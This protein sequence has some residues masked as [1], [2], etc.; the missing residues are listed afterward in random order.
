MQ[1]AAGNTRNQPLQS[2]DPQ[3]DWVLENYDSQT[4][5]R[6]NI[7]TEIRRLQALKSFHMLDQ[8]VEDCYQRFA[9]LAARMFRTPMAAICLVDLGRTWFVASTGFSPLVTSREMPRKSSACAHAIL[10][11][12]P[13][14][15]VPDLS[16]D[17]RFRHTPL[18]QQENLRFYAGAPLVTP[19]GYRLGCLSILD[20]KPR[21]QGL[22]EEDQQ[23][24]QDLAAAVMDF[25]LEKR[26]AASQAPLVFGYDIQ[27]AAV[28]L[29]ESLYSLREDSDFCTI[30][31]DTHRSLLQSACTTSDHLLSSVVS[32][33]KS[34]K[35]PLLATTAS[36][37][38]GTEMASA[39]TDG[40][41]HA[42]TGTAFAPP[43]K[44]TSTS[45]AMDQSSS[46]NTNSDKQ[47]MPPPSDKIGENAATIVVKQ[48]VQNL[49]AAME[50]FPKKVHLVFRVDPAVPP[51]IVCNDLKLF[52]SAIALLTSACER[53]E[54][55]FVRLNVY[56]KQGETAP[57]Q[58]T[59]VFECEDTGR[60][61]ALEQYHDLFQT[62]KEIDMQEDE[63]LTV[64]PSTGTILTKAVCTPDIIREAPISGGF[65]VYPVAKYVES[66]GGEYGYLPRMIRSS[67]GS[68]QAVPDTGS[69]FWF[70]IP[71]RLAISSLDA[72][73]GTALGFDCPSSDERAVVG[74]DSTDLR[75]STQRRNI[76]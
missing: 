23:A 54:Q 24:L 34:A 75:L 45:T 13:V 25:V 38:K 41:T 55:G 3:P 68:G 37:C 10:C 27:R 30:A 47:Q 53:T 63:C 19:E 18:V 9:S 76:F 69:L 73:I 26:A 29:R 11:L 60:D 48:L 33:R 44:A 35:A 67:S 22:L 50:V 49:V 58:T 6:P 8:P 51:E 40:T 4:T 70:S 17:E 74:T 20:H 52:R 32:T 21:P 31:S 12:R 43:A 64:D 65:A 14:M 46:N 7:E 66:M 59:L 36:T 42:A 56:T 2:A 16:L 72:A 39:A 57:D 62:P 71:L 61:V 15:V 1:G 5:E 28:Q